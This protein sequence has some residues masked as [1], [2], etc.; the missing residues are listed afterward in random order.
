MHHCS[1]SIPCWQTMLI[2]TV[3]N[4]KEI[5]RLTLA[6]LVLKYFNF[7]ISNIYAKY[8]TMYIMKRGLGLNVYVIDKLYIKIYI[9]I[10]IL[11]TFVM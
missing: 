4:F 7:Q 2:S 11:T 9:Y 1:Q 5:K 3:T 6:K 8:K 10:Y